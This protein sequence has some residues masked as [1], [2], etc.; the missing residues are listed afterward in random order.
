MNP[1]AVTIGSYQ[2][3]RV[4]NKLTTILILEIKRPERRY[5]RARIY[6]KNIRTGRIITLKSD[7]HIF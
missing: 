1:K 5:A 3:A 2:L 6:A 4:G 7:A